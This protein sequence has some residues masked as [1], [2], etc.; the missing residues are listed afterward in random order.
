VLRT[1]EEKEK[2]ASLEAKLEKKEAIQKKT[3]DRI[4]EVRSGS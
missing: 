3:Q 2:V 1:E 4:N